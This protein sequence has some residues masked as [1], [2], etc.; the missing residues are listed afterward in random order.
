MVAGGQVVPCSKQFVHDWK[1][2]SFAH[3]GE[4]ARR[5]HPSLHTATPCPDFK[6]TKSCPRGD[7]CTMAHGPWE[8]GLHPD[9]FK[10][11]LCA[12]GK[13]CQRRM[14][15][16]A[17]DGCELRSPQPGASQQLM[18]QP[19]MQM[20]G[21]QG[22]S[23]WQSQASQQQVQMGG[24]RHQP[25]NNFAGAAQRG[26]S[27]HQR[28]RS[29]GHVT[30]NGVCPV[31]P[32]Q[33]V[34]NV[35]LGFEDMSMPADRKAQAQSG[36]ITAPKAWA[37]GAQVPGAGSN[38]AVRGI[39]STAAS[40]TVPVPNV[41]PANSLGPGGKPVNPR[42]GNPNLRGVASFN[43]TRMSAA[44]EGE[45]PGD[46][47]VGLKPMPDT[48]G[49]GTSG[50]NG[51]M[52]LQAAQVQSPEWAHSDSPVEETSWVDKLLDSTLDFE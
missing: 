12:Y 25:F 32:G 22:P 41:G 8:A 27:G 33:Q 9:A 44:S 46:D 16:F 31:V 42:R 37:P 43:A 11:N 21:G 4:T 34:P 15:F 14:C 30:R 20:G 51:K 49:I 18:Q 17:H 3:E 38:P 28:G 5:R 19:V 47:D 36:G 1:E 6:S 52:D 39:T 40:N 2:C 45:I 35:G 24:N 26:G 48:E 10:T 7:S 23:S 13:G 29:S 50:G